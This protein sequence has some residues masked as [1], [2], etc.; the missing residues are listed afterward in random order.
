MTID[1][2]GRVMVGYADGC[3]PPEIDAA[4]RLR[5][6]H[7]G[8]PANGLV[9]HGAILRQISGKTL[10]KAYD[11]PGTE[12][13]VA[14]PVATPGTGGSDGP[15]LPATGATPALALAG[16]VLLTLLVVVHRRRRA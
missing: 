1:K 14:P 4:E 10:F 7:R 16:L 5:R 9:N 3:V 12:P 6:Q 11:V 15:G 8:G 2:T 13:V